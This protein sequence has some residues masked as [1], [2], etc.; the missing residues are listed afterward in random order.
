[1][2]GA[3][4]GVL[5]VVGHATDALLNAVGLAVL[6]Y[7]RRKVRLSYVCSRGPKARLTLLEESSR[8]VRVHPHTSA[9]C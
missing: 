2:V 5:T 1:M 7:G 3:V 9:N 6:V 4:M 8:V